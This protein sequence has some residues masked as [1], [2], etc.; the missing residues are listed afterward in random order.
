MASAG[1]LEAVSQNK[2]KATVAGLS[3]AARPVKR[4][5]SKA[6]C[7]CRA[8]KVRCDVVENGSPCT[9]CRLDEVECV[10]TESKRKKKNRV[11]GDNLKPSSDTSAEISE[12][13][14]YLFSGKT[15]NIKSTSSA[16]AGSLPALSP[17]HHGIELDQGHHH[18]PH[19]IYRNQRQRTKD[20]K[21][22]RMSIATTI[23][24]AFVCNS[25]LAT[26]PIMPPG[27]GQLSLSSPRPRPRHN[28]PCYIRPLPAKFQEDDID[29]I[30]RKGALTIPGDNLRNE[31]LKS[32]LQYVHTYMPLLDLDDFLQII[33][34]NEPAQLSLLLFQAVMFAGTAFV[35]VKHLIAAGY[36]S[37]KVARKV[38]FQ[39][40]RLLYDFDYEVDR[41]SLV[42]SLLLMTNWYEMPDDQKDTWHWMGVS[43]SL[44]HTIGLHRDPANSNM[45]PRRQRLWKRIW[46]ST[47]TRD[48]LIA[49]GMRRPT[50]IKDEDCDVPML[51]VNDFEFKPF[52]R[53][54][55]QAMGDCELVHNVG[56]QKELATMFIQKAKLCLCISRVLSAQYSVL[57]HK[58]GGTTETTMML[59]P[60]KSIAASCDIRTCD[61]ELENWMT[62]LPEVARYHT[63]TA[64]SLSPGEEVLQVHR[65]LLKMIYLTTSSALH[66]P[67]VLPANPFPTVEVE[68]QAISRNKVRH[69]A[70]EITRIAQELHRYDLTRYMPTTG[71]TVLL[72]AVIIHLL[73]IKSNDVG[74][75]ASS[76][77]RFYQCMNILQRLRE[78]YASADFAL[79]FLEAAI[80]KAGIHV[81][82]Q[83][84]PTEDDGQKFATQTASHLHG[85]LDTL[86]P[87]P[88]STSNKLFINPS[89]PF[90]PSEPPT[91]FSFDRGDE[92]KGV[93]ASTPPH[94]DGSENGSQQP[95]AEQDFSGN[96]NLFGAHDPG[97][98]PDLVEFMNLAHDA[99]ITQNDLDALINFEDN[100]GDFFTT[101]DIF[102]M[103]LAMP[104]LES[105]KVDPEDNHMAW[106]Q[107]T[108]RQ[109]VD[110]T[111]NGSSTAGLD[112]CVDYKINCGSPVG[113]IQTFGP[114]KDG[115]RNVLDSQEQTLQEGMHD[116]G[117]VQHPNSNSASATNGISSPA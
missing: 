56:H 54:V 18:V 36:E 50:R 15:E 65:A 35:D 51:T 4:R 14:Q 117:F 63:P 11:D 82:T 13:S 41:I 100:G 108:T 10:V 44:A 12:D 101:D 45:E 113:S 106:M 72:P 7:C 25:S 48:R 39:R 61:D 17:G 68:L 66:R 75:R 69:A 62:S 42:Q 26:P 79:S 57:S 16:I 28:L 58:F 114:D 112:Q 64:S 6:C 40:A 78:I 21:Q 30:E 27:F 88:D 74:V 99:D 37:R 19:L 80:K 103:D 94:S 32:Y 89:L 92:M 87:P 97:L 2:R 49:L 23:T 90:P 5:A 71:V 77:H 47:Y 34:R 93:V 20:D 9:N 24:P 22:R 96:M 1:V 59:V 86:T 67:Q 55:M 98:E 85:R 111:L 52:S 104:G 81:S 115:V 43:L 91:T 105:D 29:Y 109:S 70:V 60:K 83:V 38:F 95:S 31:L 116:S 53:E 76:L 3:G 8:R 84:P 73:D 46:W 102:K 107:D 110:S 33:L